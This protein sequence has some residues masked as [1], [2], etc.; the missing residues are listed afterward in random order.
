MLE[1]VGFGDVTVF[2]DYTKAEPTVDHI[3][4]VFIARK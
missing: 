4:L 2:G 1:Q 3:S